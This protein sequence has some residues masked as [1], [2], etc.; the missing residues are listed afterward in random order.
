MN[1]EILVAFCAFALVGSITPGPNNLMLMT[2]G[3]NFGFMRSWPHMIGVAMGF[4]L[5]M[6]FGALVFGG[7]VMA[8]IFDQYSKYR[9]YLNLKH[10]GTLPLAEGIR[11]LALRHGI[12]TTSTMERLKKLRAMGA[13]DGNTADSLRDAF[14]FIT[15]I[16]LRQQI[17]DYQAGRK[18]TNFVNPSDLTKRKK[19]L[20][21]DSLKAINEFRAEL[22]S[23][24]TGEVF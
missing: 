4:V 6:V 20:L 23:E 5:Q 3:A 17:A 11:L 14:A 7:Q 24:L 9:G 21:K 12:E 10:S 8:W 18:V 2:S 19:R 16:Q 15:R 1:T 13:V 22:R